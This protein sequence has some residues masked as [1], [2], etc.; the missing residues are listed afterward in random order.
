MDS[1][2][3]I[4]H[5]QPCEVN[6]FDMDDRGLGCRLKVL[7]KNDPYNLFVP[8][9]IPIEPWQS[10]EDRMLSHT[11]LYYDAYHIELSKKYNRHFIYQ[12]ILGDDLVYNHRPQY[13]GWV[14]CDFPFII[15]NTQRKIF[16]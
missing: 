9:I 7:R 3:K 16:S 13:H 12:G 1:I 15:M 6:N 11:E 8:M 10:I 5:L 2:F 4:V 14:T